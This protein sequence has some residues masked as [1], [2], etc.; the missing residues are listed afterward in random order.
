[1][2]LRFDDEVLAVEAAATT[3]S[4]AR[5][6][7]QQRIVLAFRQQ[8]EDLGP[9]PTDADIQSFA[10]L[11]LVEK[12]LQKELDCAHVLAEELRTVH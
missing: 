4:R 7:A 10:R 6:F 12:A 1:M 5:E 3:A 9:G 2:I 11:A 8:L